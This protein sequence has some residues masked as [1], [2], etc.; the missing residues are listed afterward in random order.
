[1]IPVNSNVPLCRE[2]EMPIV[3]CN[4]CSMILAERWEVMPKRETP[5]W[6]PEVERASDYNFRQEKVAEYNQEVLHSWAKVHVYVDPLEGVDDV[7][8]F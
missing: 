8:V 2:H 5:A 7:E 1:M 4:P 6:N 3:R